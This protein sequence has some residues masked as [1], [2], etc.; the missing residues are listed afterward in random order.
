MKPVF[1]LDSETWCPIQSP[2]PSAI[3]FMYVLHWSVPRG[4]EGFLSLF[5]ASLYIQPASL[6]FASLYIQPALQKLVLILL[7]DPPQ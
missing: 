6:F 7:C 3:S 4:E 1:S 2:M 5:F